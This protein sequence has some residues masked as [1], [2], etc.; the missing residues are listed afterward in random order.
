[1]ASLFVREDKA[2]MVVSIDAW[3]NGTQLAEARHGFQAQSGE[4]TYWVPSGN[5]T[6]VG[7]HATVKV[8]GRTVRTPSNVHAPDRIRVM[9]TWLDDAGKALYH[10]GADLLLDPDDYNWLSD[11][12]A[13]AMS[14]DMKTLGFSYVASD[15]KRGA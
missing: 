4:R 14:Q 13:E 15:P 8:T 12:V 11:D 5:Y 7:R 1:M 2:G 10:G 3:A 9:V 6:G